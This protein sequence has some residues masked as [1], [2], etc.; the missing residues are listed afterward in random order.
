MC[1]RYDG[2]VYRALFDST[3]IEEL[4]EQDVS[5]SYKLYLQ[6]VLHPER[7]NPKNKL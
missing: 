4:N 2:D 6:Y 7:K 3:K 5:D 1:L